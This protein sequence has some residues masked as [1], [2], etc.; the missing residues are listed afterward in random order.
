MKL[1]EHL[2]H[3][4]EEA[5]SQL[6]SKEQNEAYNKERIANLEAEMTRLETRM[7]TIKLQMKSKDIT[8]AQLQQLKPLSV[9]QKQERTSPAVESSLK[10]DR[11]LGANESQSSGVRRA[12]AASQQKEET[13]KKAEYKA[14]MTTSYRMAYKEPGEEYYRNKAHSVRNTQP[15]SRGEKPKDEEKK[16]AVVT[17]KVSLK[18]HKIARNIENN[19]STLEKDKARVIPT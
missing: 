14:D 9:D 8:I 16:E 18:E 1:N 12:R 2:K 4:L 13:G 15:S 7:N 3:D 10:S 17:K 19:I 6:L 5:R 11:H